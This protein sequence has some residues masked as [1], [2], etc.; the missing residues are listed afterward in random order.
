MGDLRNKFQ[1]D[2]E[3]DKMERDELARVLKEEQQTYT[4]EKNILVDRIFVKLG[5]LTDADF[6][7]LES[8]DH[9]V[10]MGGFLTEKKLALRGR[11]LSSTL[12]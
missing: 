8:P 6:E 12:R 4:D 2:D 7:Q 1:R 5:M 10:W 11:A 9:L 3:I